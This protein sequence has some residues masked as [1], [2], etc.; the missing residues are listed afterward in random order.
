MEVSGALSCSRHLHIVTLVQ[1]FR[2]LLQGLR[3]RGIRFLVTSR[4]QLDGGLHG[5]KH[6]SIGSLSPEYAVDLLRQEAGE[7]LVMPEQAETLAHI[8]GKNALA[9]TII[10]GFIA[11][12]AVTAEVRPVYRSLKA[13]V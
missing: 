2:D 12:Q 11:C 13:G 4:C 6:I 5:T 1:G 10:G 7:K 3:G 9:L 8:C